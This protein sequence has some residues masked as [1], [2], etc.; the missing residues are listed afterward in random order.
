MAELHWKNLAEYDAELY[1][2][3]DAVVGVDEAGRGP[4]AGPVCAVACI[5]P[6]TSLETEV[7]SG[8]DDSKKLSENKRE[9]LF[10]VIDEI[11]RYGISYVSAD[12]IDEKNIL[13]ATMQC[14][15]QAV[16]GIAEHLEGGSA[17]ILFDGNKVPEFECGT[18]PSNVV[19]QSLVKGDATSASVAAASVL[20]KVSRDRYMCELHKKYPLYAFDQHKG[21]GTKLHYECI[22]EHG[23]CPEHRRSFLKKLNFETK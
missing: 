5:L 22:A 4:L 8:L 15:A 17:L 21:Y 18:L 1:K 13:T 7:L 19:L 10:A 11:A 14:M 16:R 6:K 3:Y 9:K 12:V 20:A 23:M 2:K